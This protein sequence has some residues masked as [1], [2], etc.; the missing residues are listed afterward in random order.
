MKAFYLVKN[1][2]ANEAFELREIFLP[3][4]GEDEVLIKTEAFGLNF[5]DV[6]ARLGLYRECPPLPTVIGYEAVGIIEKIGSEVKNVKVGDRV[7]AFSRFGGYA[8]HVL[9]PQLAVVP[10]DSN[11]PS[12]VALALAVQYSTAWYALEE[13]MNLHPGDRVLVHA[14]AGGVGTALIQLAKR[15]GC[16]IA[17]TASSHKMDYLT[18][19]GVEFPI[20]YRKKDF[21]QELINSGWAGKVDAIF[22]PIGGV[23]VRKG[24]NLLGGGGKMLVFGGSSMSDA[25]NLFQKLKIAA[26]FGIWS[27]IVLMKRSIS[28]IGVNMLRISES[29]PEL[30]HHCMVQVVDLYN[31]GELEPVVGME[32]STKDLAEAHS[33]LESRQSTGKVIVH[34]DLN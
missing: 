18:K 21:E 16:I 12:G 7:I 24:M 23:S 1:G 31:K 29:K 3:D 6:M 15:R 17:G 9:T 4:P 5:A 22:D 20:D 28:L 34:W 30:L 33:F 10:V 19:Q 25:N 26:G 13:C 14:A 8:S 2:P 27:P 32:F 11:I